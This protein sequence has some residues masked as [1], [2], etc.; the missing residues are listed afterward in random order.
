MNHDSRLITDF[1]RD[2][3][4]LGGSAPSDVYLI[5]IIKLQEMA[6]LHLQET[7]KRNFPGLRELAPS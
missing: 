1:K 7:A 4:R 5:G 6:G 2:I 3:G